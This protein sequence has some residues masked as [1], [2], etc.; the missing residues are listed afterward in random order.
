MH[1]D[2]NLVSI[3]LGLT[4]FDLSQDE[5]GR[6]CSKRWNFSSA[7]TA[8]PLSKSEPVLPSHHGNREETVGEAFRR[9]SLVTNR[10]PAIENLILGCDR[11][12]STIP[13]SPLDSPGIT[14]TISSPVSQDCRLPSLCKDVK[15]EEGVDGEGSDCVESGAESG[16][17]VTKVS[18]HQHNY[19]T[20]IHLTDAPE[21]N[22]DWSLYTSA[23]GAYVPTKQGEILTYILPVTFRTDSIASFPGSHPAFHCLQYRKMGELQATVGGGG[24]G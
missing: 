5:L 1:F 22:K 16:N 18:L 17:T 7:T 2:P 14:M 20:L 10:T 9:M 21:S 24:G 19:Q 3:Y 13:E 23:D 15:R 6:L 11:S 4:Q 8:I 12:F